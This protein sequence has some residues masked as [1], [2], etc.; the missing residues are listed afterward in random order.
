MKK[1]AEVRP[2]GFRETSEERLDPGLLRETERID[3]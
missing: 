1:A 3:R 2:G